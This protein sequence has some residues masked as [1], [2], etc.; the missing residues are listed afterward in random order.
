[1]PGVRTLEEKDT[2]Q[3]R[4]SSRGAEIAD[5]TSIAIENANKCE[6][7]FEDSL[8]YLQTNKKKEI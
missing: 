3:G 1:M 5:G 8:H 4:G 2:K 7:P 6:E